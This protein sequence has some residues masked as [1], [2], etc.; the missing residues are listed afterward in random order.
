MNSDGRAWAATVAVVAVCSAVAAALFVVTDSAQAAVTYTT[1]C[2]SPPGSP[3][4]GEIT[5]DAIETRNQ[6]IADTEICEALAE[7]LERIVARLG[8]VEDEIAEGA[9]ESTAAQRV[10]LAPRDRQAATL[11]WYG[12]W[13]TVGLLFVVIVATAWYGSWRVLRD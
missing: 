12:S 2:P 13:A 5:D 6:R 11:A 10:A 8:D 1:E 4:P 3:E 9:E 7:R